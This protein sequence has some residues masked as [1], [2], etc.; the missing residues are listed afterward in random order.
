MDTLHHEDVWRAWLDSAEGSK[1]T[2]RLFIHAKSPQNVQS[3]WVRAHLIDVTFNPQWNSVEVAQAM[4]STLDA[5][6]QYNSRD[7]T[8][9]SEPG[10]VDAGPVCG[11]FVFCT[12]TCVPLRS[13]A[14]VGGALFE[15][16]CSWLNAYHTPVDKYDGAAAFGA[17]NK[18]I[19]PPKVR[20]VQ[21]ILPR[22]AGES[23]CLLYI[24]IQA[25]W[26]SLPGWIVLNRRHA[27]EV[28]ALAN[29]LGGWGQPE[30]GAGDG[31]KPA[32]VRRVRYRGTQGV[33]WRE[34]AVSAD[35]K[36]SSEGD[37]ETKTEGTESGGVHAEATGQAAPSASTATEEREPAPCTAAVVVA[38]APAVAATPPTGPDSDCDAAL[39]EAWATV[40]APEEVFFATALA[41][42]GYLRDPPVP[43]V[44]GP[45]G[46]VTTGEVRIL[47]VNSA[48]WARRGDAHPIQHSR[49]DADLVRRMTAQGALFGRKFAPG[50]VSA[51]QWR[52]V[53]SQ[54]KQGG[55]HRDSAVDGAYERTERRGD[56]DGRGG[57]SYSG[58]QPYENQRYS[59]SGGRTGY[60]GY[61]G[62]SAGD[63]GHSGGWSDGDRYHS[64]HRDSRE[65]GHYSHSHDRERDDSRR[66]EHDRDRYDG[67]TQQAKRRRY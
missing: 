23:P 39:L 34:A 10:S 36:Q 62:Y 49:F 51:Q 15:R 40:H 25:V 31:D 2:A 60:S 1:Y 13:L 32:T 17:V 24:T 5:A 59:S 20:V 44:V 48:E 26:K 54:V 8:T 43:P 42:L 65:Q 4:L 55:E 52:T 18:D 14:E 46:A 45:E 37:A 63:R 27:A 12:E 38:T 35:A 58:Q 33:R 16:D 6:F 61:S 22:P 7:T 56:K 29:L 3:E 28:L 57:T 30:D 47:A 41:L 64:T 9:G 53:L 67:D 66:R 50:S 21:P 19:V 11:R